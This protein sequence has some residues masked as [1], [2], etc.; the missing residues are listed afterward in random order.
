[1][2][3]YSLGRD[4]G[5]EHWLG[6]V[7]GPMQFVGISSDWLFPRG[8]IV[9]LTER[10]ALAGIPVSYGDIVSPDGHDAFLKEWDQMT[11]VLKPFIDANLPEVEA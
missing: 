6:Q 2:D 3:Q 4:G 11:A 5:E 9:A 7:R 8:P 1:M 10:A